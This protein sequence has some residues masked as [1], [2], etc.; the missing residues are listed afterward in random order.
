VKRLCAGVQKNSH[1]DTKKKNM[2]GQGVFYPE[3]SAKPSHWQGGLQ[4]R[5]ASQEEFQL[6]L[7]F[8]LVKS[9]AS[10]WD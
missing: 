10:C 8:Q 5:P 7:H 9:G 1:E 2:N 4:C 3:T 6:L